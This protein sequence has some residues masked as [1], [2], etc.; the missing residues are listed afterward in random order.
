MERRGTEGVRGIER[1]PEREREREREREGERER[2]REKG[3]RIERKKYI[4][5]SRERFFWWIFTAIADFS[6]ERESEWVSE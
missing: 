6:R 1:N 2:E 3:R 4:F 5:S